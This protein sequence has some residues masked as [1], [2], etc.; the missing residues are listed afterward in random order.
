MR[1]RRGP[2]RARGTVPGS[3]EQA[4]KTWLE[5][6][7]DS[8][9]AGI[10][11]VAMDGIGWAPSSAAAEEL[12]GTV[13]VMDPSTPAP[14]PLGIDEREHEPLR[15]PLPAQRDLH[16]QRP[17]L[18]GRYCRQTQQLP[19]HHLWPPHPHKKHLPNSLVPPL[20]TTIHSARSR[21]FS[22]LLNNI[23]SC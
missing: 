16:H 19:R 5:G 9:K 21:C 7:L 11:V 23:I 18:P 8:W 2:S 4:L 20:D 12:P 6:R 17:P 15:A 13:P 22:I 1:E 3:C 10:E 14:Q